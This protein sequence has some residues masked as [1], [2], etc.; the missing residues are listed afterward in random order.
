MKKATA[1]LLSAIFGPVTAWL[2]S[3]IYHSKNRYPDG[4]ESYLN[5]AE[6]MPDSVHGPLIRE[7]FMLA[8]EGNP[9]NEGRSLMPLF[10]H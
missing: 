2:A 5:Y 1:I 3:E 6:T 8:T 7:C 10:N 4:I 9:R